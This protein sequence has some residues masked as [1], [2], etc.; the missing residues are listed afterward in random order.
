MLPL[1]SWRRPQRFRTEKRLQLTAICC[2]SVMSA[3]TFPDKNRLQ[4]TALC[5]SSV[6]SAT[7]FP[8]KNRL[9]L[10]AI[11]C[12]SVM[13]ATTFPDKNRLQLTALCC[14]SVM[15]ATTFPDKNRLQL[16]ALCFSSA[17]GTRLNVSGQE[18]ARGGGLLSWSGGSW[19]TSSP[20]ACLRKPATTAPPRGAGVSMATPSTISGR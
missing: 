12:R 14:R 19:T 16:T 2:R 5:C 10:A 9:Q 3:T 17:V 8:D 13:S 20:T 4:L 18:R 11:C 6:M 15:S 1:Y 7:T